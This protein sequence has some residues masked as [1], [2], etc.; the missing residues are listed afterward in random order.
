METNIIANANAVES[1]AG[2]R[3]TVARRVF[4]FVMLWLAGIVAL[5][6]VAFIIRWAIMP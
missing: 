3:D 1:G 5:S 6:I 4:W 2:G